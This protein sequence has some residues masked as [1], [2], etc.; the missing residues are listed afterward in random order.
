[1][2]VKNFITIYQ[3]S[4][5][6]EKQLLLESNEYEYKKHKELIMKIV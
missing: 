5:D 2:L 3:S 6:R 4:N 1:M